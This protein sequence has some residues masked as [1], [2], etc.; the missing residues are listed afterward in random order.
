MEQLNFTVMTDEE[1]INRFFIYENKTIN[2]MML[3]SQTEMDNFLA[4]EDEIKRRDLNGEIEN[5][6]NNP[7][8][9]GKESKNN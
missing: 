3:M 5:R 2:N 1:L 4:I 8:S 9:K 6:R 7:D